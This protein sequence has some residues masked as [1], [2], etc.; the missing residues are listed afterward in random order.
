MGDFMKVIYEEPND[1]VKYN[2]WYDDNGSFDI[3]YED[4]INL[5]DYKSK[6]VPLELKEFLDKWNNKINEHKKIYK[7]EYPVKMAKIEFIYND[8]VYVIYPVCVSATYKSNFMSDKE[9]D[10]SFDSLFE[11]YEKEIREDLEKELGVKYSRYWG[12]LD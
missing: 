12:M 7:E 10:V 6:D 3:W 9:Y 8:I 4:T 5:I 11:K 1:K 2:K